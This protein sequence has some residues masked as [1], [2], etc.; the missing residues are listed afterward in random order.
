MLAHALLAV[1]AAHDDATRP[2]PAG[3]FALTCNE[4]QRLL[5]SLSPGTCPRLGLPRGLVH[6]APMPPTLSLFHPA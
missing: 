4:V 5:T 3:L 6:L 2:A 1:I